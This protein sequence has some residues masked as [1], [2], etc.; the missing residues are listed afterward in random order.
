MRDLGY[1]VLLVRFAAMI[2]IKTSPVRAKL[3]GSGTAVAKTARLLPTARPLGL[4]DD[5][6]MIDATPVTGL[7]IAMVV[8]P[9][10]SRFRAL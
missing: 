4:S 3:D 5:T 9:P 10:P 8:E 2:A 1:A 6:L 7:C